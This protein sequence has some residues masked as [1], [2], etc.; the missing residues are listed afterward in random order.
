M[1]ERTVAMRSTTTVVRAGKSHA[2]AMRRRE[3]R[4][5]L[6][7]AAPYLIGFV[8]WVAGPILASLFL[9]FFYYY[10]L[11]MTW[12]GF[13]NYVRAFTSDR[14]FYPSYWRTF[15]YTAA[16]VPLG[17]MTSLALAM[18]LN[19]K[20]RGTSFFR[21]LFYAPSLTPVTAL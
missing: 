14:Q 19:R 15:Y 5:G 2:G 4:W 13:G 7:F 1:T 3:A 18:L 6:L 17:L 9:S 16:S 11:S 21:T 8:L 10:I 12:I 20:V